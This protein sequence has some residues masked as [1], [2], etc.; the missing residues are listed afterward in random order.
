VRWDQALGRRLARHHLGAPAPRKDLADVVGALCGIHAQVMTSAEHS[1]GLRVRGM[2]ASALSD[3]LWKTRELVKAYGPRG[4]VHLLP[5]KEFG[6]WLAALRDTGRAEDDAGRLE[7]LGMSAKDLASVADAI[8]ESL[9]EKPLTREEL[10][11]AVAKRVGRWAVERTVVAF[12]GQ[13]QV[14]QAGIGVV[15]RRGLVCFGPPVGAKVTFVR[16]ESWLGPFRVGD[17]AKSQ[18]EMMRRYLAAYG[19]ATAAEFAQWAT[20][21]PARAKQ[22]ANELGSV[23]EEVEVDGVRALQIAGDRAGRPARSTL[24]VPR[25]D[26]YVVGSHPRDVVIPPDLVKR[27]T[28]TG[29]LRGGIGTGRSYLAGPMPVMLIDGVVSGIWESKR[30]GRRL[31]IVAQP[32]VRIDAKRR[33]ELARSAARLGEISGLEATLRIGAVTTRPH[34]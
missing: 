30:R 10:G 1:L 11:R 12:G 15:A 28:A 27:A 29:L 16:A 32:L 26:V 13:S 21:A 9:S 22:L 33:T 25:F 20:I 14:W 19:P 24:L 6:F 7:Y 3:A 31:D 17:A 34:L 18:R 5:A 23:I 2:T 8:A 4:T